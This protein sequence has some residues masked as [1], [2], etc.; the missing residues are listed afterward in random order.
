MLRELVL[1]QWRLGSVRRW[2]VVVERATNKSPWLHME[3][4]SIVEAVSPRCGAHPLAGWSWAPPGTRGA[5][6]CRWNKAA[7]IPRH[8]GRHRQL[9]LR[10]DGTLPILSQSS[11]PSQSGEGPFDDPSVRQHFEALGGVRSLDDLHDVPLG[12]DLLVP[13]GRR[14]GAKAAQEAVPFQTRCR[15]AAQ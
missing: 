13:P 14:G 7:G 15:L 11:A 9:V 5:A 4:C 1:D 2:S 6:V 8:D 10:V 3:P 12:R